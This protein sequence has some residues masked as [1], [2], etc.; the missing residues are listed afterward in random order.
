MLH[1]A[2]SGELDPI[3]LEK[4]AGLLAFAIDIEPDYFKSAISKYGTELPAA[5]RGIIS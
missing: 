5:V 4:L 3:E 2:A 1:R